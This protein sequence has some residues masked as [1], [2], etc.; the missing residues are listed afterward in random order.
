[1]PAGCR[2]PPLKIASK[3]L[4]NLLRCESPTCL[5]FRTINYDPDDHIYRE[6][7]GNE[8]PLK[9][10][11]VGGVAM[12]PL[13][14]GYG[15]GNKTA[16]VYFLD[17]AITTWFDFGNLY[18]V[19]PQLLFHPAQAIKALIPLEGVEELDLMN[20]I[21]RRFE[22]FE[23]VHLETDEDFNIR[24]GQPFDLF[25]LK[26]KDEKVGVNISHLFSILNAEKADFSENVL[27]TTNS[28]KGDLEPEAVEPEAGPSFQGANPF[29]EQLPVF[30]A[31]DWDLDNCTVPP[32]DQNLLESF[33]SRLS[34][35]ICFVS[36]VEAS[37]PSEFHGWP[38]KIDMNS[39]KDAVEKLFTKELLP[40]C[41]NLKAFYENPDNR[42]RILEPEVKTKFES[43]GRVYVM[44]KGNPHY[45][46]PW[47][48]AEVIKP[49]SDKL[50][51]KHIDT[52]RKEEVSWDET[53]RIHRLHAETPPFAVQFRVEGQAD[54]DEEIVAKWKESFQCGMTYSV[55]GDI[56]VQFVSGTDERF[57]NLVDTRGDVV[58]V[59]NVHSYA[60][61]ESILPPV[62]SSTISVSSNENA[63]IST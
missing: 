53:C 35:E 50:L 41:N 48:R 49:M 15:R 13:G 11:K 7:K 22:F 61:K 2:I 17:E 52:G 24:S 6:I 42:H 5:Y 31:E 59:K 39:W 16:K 34:Q 45:L 60:S 44:C 55:S 10:L 21:L 56:E 46:G 26:R 58:S 25:G 40:F 33:K 4:V 19:P 14:E 54:D 43:G 9:I 57:A 28:S 27:K 29:S 37:T 36:S 12:A 30:N 3:A 18:H 47:L 38:V 23:L 32:F 51:V 20:S 62:A 1:M 8:K 63:D